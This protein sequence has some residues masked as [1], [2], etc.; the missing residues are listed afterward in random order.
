MH[1]HISIMIYHC[2]ERKQLV[3]LFNLRVSLWGLLINKGQKVY[4]K[5]IFDMKA[6]MQAA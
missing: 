6:I 5:L 1:I 2:D 3:H 4:L